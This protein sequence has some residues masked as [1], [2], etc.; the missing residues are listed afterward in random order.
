MDHVIRLG[1][2]NSC[3]NENFGDGLQGELLWWNCR[4]E[5]SQRSFGI[6][7]GGSPKGKTVSRCRWNFT[8]TRSLFMAVFTVQWSSTIMDCD[9]QGDL[10]AWCEHVASGIS[11]SCDNF[12]LR[13]K[14]T[15]EV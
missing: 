2:R 10:L 12:L 7:G 1:G 15:E 8:T 9:C 3:V 4:P 5:N 6:S 14:N 13:F 11:V